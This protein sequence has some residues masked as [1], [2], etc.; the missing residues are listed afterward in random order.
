M[1][2][3][4]VTPPTVLDQFEWKGVGWVTLTKPCTFEPFRSNRLE[5]VRVT[6]QTNKQIETHSDT[7][8]LESGTKV[9]E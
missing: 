4:L 3:C 7:S 6:E 2:V 5:R 8:K 1:S 9:Q